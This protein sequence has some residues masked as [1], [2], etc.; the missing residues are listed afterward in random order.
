MPLTEKWAEL[1]RRLDV[2][3]NRDKLTIEE[4]EAFWE[5]RANNCEIARMALD[6]LRRAN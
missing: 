4:L 1:L 5:E 2:R 3:N 6:A